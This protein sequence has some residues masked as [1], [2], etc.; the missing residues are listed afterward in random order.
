[1]KVFLPLSILPLSILL[2]CG[3][4][5]VGGITSTWTQPYTPQS[6]GQGGG[7]SSGGGS[8]PSSPGSP[9]V[10]VNPAGIWDI[11]DTVNGKP[12]AE[13]ALVA[14]GK[15]FSLATSDPFGCPDVSGGTYTIDGSTFTGSGVTAMLNNNCLPPDGHNYLTYTLSG[16]MLNSQ[17]DLSLDVDGMLVPTLGATMDRLYGEPSSLARLTGNWN[18]GGNTLTVNPDGTF[19][20]QQGSGCVVN[21]S[22]TI[23]DPNHNIYGVSFEITNCSS[24]L[25]GITFTGLA[26][27]DDTN[28][29]LW[30]IR[31]D[32]SGPD[33]ANGGALV[34]VFDVIGHM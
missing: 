7:S 13:V 31:E 6:A 17:L 3:C 28:P 25:A 21:G 11:T 12:V 15:Y 2:L 18:D 32:V 8:P 20:E 34:V 4:S 26:Y 29:S 22:Y 27:V 19:F 1:M 30:L 14:D 16:Y 5:G 9:G 24:S 33:P 10:A 23:I